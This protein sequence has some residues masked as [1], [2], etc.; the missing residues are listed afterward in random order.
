MC[1]EYFYRFVI[2]AVIFETLI[3]HST[4]YGVTERP[5]IEDVEDVGDFRVRNI[6]TSVLRWGRREGCE[7]R[8]VAASCPSCDVGTKRQEEKMERPFANASRQSCLSEL[9]TSQT[10]SN[11]FFCNH[12]IFV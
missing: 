5:K 10:F 7:G 9:S 6:C 8:F 3:L 2:V 11:P 4:F 1:S 12:Q